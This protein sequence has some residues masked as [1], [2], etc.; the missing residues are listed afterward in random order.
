LYVYADYYIAC[1]FTAPEVLLR[2]PYDERSDMWSV[3]VIAYLLLSGDLP[4]M[5][6]SQK[7]LFQN[8]VRGECCTTEIVDM[9]NTNTDHLQYIFYRR[10]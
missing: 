9:L 6:R 3:G 4:F 2:H 10:L 8:I 7:E 5:G 1:L